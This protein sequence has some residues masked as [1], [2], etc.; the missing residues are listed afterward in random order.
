MLSAYLVAIIL[1]LVV[2]SC[3]FVAGA[4]WATRGVEEHLSPPDSW[5]G[6]PRSDP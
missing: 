1:C 6:P 2:F 4:W 5:I 3:G